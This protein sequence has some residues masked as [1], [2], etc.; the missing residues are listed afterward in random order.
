MNDIIEQ[1]KKTPY[2]RT[3]SSFLGLNSDSRIFDAVKAGNYYI[4]CQGSAGHYCYPRTLLPIDKYSSL[5]VAVYNNK[6]KI[7]NIA[8][9]SVLK[10]FPQ[11]SELLECNDGNILGW[12]EINL[13]NNLYKYLKNYE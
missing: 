5:E 3:N 4:S 8:K 11:Y 9:S 7:I 1:L 6:R 13:L 2:K 12:V 10:K